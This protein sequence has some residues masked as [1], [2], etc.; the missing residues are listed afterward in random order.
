[1]LSDGIIDLHNKLK[2]GEI[3]ESELIKVSLK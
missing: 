3:K 1:M 2:N